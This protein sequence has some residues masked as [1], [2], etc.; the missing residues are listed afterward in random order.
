MKFLLL[1][2]MCPQVYEVL[3]G[4]VKKESIGLSL[5]AS[6]PAARYVG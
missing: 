4:S 1:G 3:P 6:V 2:S 5:E